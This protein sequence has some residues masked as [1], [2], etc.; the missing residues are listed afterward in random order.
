MAFVS[1]C[2]GDEQRP[3]PG[4]LHRWYGVK[5]LGEDA[6]EVSESESPEAGLLSS[7]SLTASINNG[8][9]S[10]FAAQQRFAD[11]NAQLAK[12]RAHRDSVESSV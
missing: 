12:A 10:G 1:F 2:H 6:S 7:Q 8:S 11:L 4:V 3:K 5:L 9:T